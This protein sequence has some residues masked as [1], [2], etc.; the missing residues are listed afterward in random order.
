MLPGE[1]KEDIRETI[2]LI[3]KSKF[4]FFQVMRFMPIPGTPIFNELV[5]DGEIPSNYMPPHSIL[6]FSV[7]EKRATQIVQPKGS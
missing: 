2:K 1:T 4:D 7:W 6:L 3:R 5:R